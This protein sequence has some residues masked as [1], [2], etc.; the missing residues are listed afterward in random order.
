MAAYGDCVLCRE[1][2]IQK[3]K[4]LL[5][6]QMVDMIRVPAQHDDFWD[7]TRLP[8]SISPDNVRVAY[9]IVIPSLD[10]GLCVTEL[11]EGG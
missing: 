4:E 8:N 11:P 7:I 10:D 9:K 5:L 6:E 3:A 2:Q 1:D